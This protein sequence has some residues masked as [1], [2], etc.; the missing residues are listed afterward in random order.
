MKNYIKTDGFDNVIELQL[1]VLVLQQ[2]DYYVAYC[3]SLNLSSYGDTIDDAKVGFDE[4]M[5]AYLEECKE[6]GT[7]HD[8]L[9]KNGWTFNIHNHKKAE[10]PAMVELNIPAGVLRQQFN[11][12][13]SVPVC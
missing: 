12:N 1:N 3:P 10:P 7:L 8:D 2:G 13:W 5:E 9:V 4:V 6:N 11:E